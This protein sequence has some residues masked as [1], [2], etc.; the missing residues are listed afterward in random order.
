MAIISWFFCIGICVVSL[1]W[2]QPSGGD[3]SFPE[4]CQALT[5]ENPLE[6]CP[7]NT[8]LV[9]APNEKARIRTI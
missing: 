5:P 2:G 7:K 1:A 8:I 9:S 3:Y 6:G 4:A